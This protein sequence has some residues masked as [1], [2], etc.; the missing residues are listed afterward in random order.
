MPKTLII[1]DFAK[2]WIAVGVERKR[3]IWKP[4]HRQDTTGEQEKR[5][6]QQVIGK[7]ETAAGTRKTGNCLFKNE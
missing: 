1:K 4:Q 7:S 5:S 6:T 2:I 3:K